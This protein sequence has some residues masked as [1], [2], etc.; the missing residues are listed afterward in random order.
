MGPCRVWAVL[1]RD[2]AALCDDFSGVGLPTAW[3]KLLPPWAQPPSIDELNL[4]DELR[5]L[6]VDRDDVVACALL[7]L[8]QAGDQLAGRVLVQAL[9]PKL[10]AL[11]R[12]DTRHD[13]GEYV[14]VAWT[15][16]MT[17]PVDLRA[18]SVLVNIALDCLKTLTRQ[19][20]RT[21]REACVL[22]LSNPAASIPADDGGTVW[23]GS[24]SSA[25]VRDYVGA[26]LD[27]ADRDGWASTKASA[28]LRSI[29]V[30][31]LSGRE[32]AARHDISHDMVRY[33][34]SHAIKTL[35]A[36]RQEVLQVLGSW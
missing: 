35:R 11:C 33:H 9:L 27:L 3:K 15:R 32:A 28:V 10:R 36:H 5:G 6:V 18:H 2:W 13:L 29:Y 24:A 14:D 4:L 12:R 16:L 25:A 17:Y 20:G 23:G 1:D 8:T 34:C 19:S 31:G 30:D 21:G 26:L 7:K 22:W